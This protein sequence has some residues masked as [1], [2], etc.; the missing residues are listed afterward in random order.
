MVD[1]EELSAIQAHYDEEPR[2]EWDRLQKRYPYEK[3]ITCKIMERYLHE[4]DKILDIGGGPGHYSVYWAKKG[5]DM[6]L[7][8]LSDGNVRFAK[9]KARQYGVRIHAGQGNA[10]DLSRYA[11]ASFDHVFLMGPL[12]HL[13]TEESR[14]QAVREATRVLKPGGL[15][16][17]SFILLYGGVNYNLRECPE[18][19]V[20]DDGGNAQL[21]DMTVRDIPFSGETFTYSYMTNVPEI[22]RFFAGFDDLEKETVFGQEGILAPY[23][24]TLDRCTARIRQQW[25]DYAV[26]FC[27]KE[28]Y[29]THAEHLMYVA[30]KK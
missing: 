11:D 15:L 3:Y 23:K 8:D 20:P 28:D 9:Q 21:Y 16:F 6:T 24:Y 17:C 5:C 7:L 19:G 30:R 10:L 1:K 26:R 27:E 4:G 25:Y 29:L 18:V 12:Y 2:L 14:V 13:M 22:R